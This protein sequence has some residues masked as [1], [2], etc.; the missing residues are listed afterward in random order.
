MQS[1]ALEILVGFFVCLG[2]AAVFLLTF[3][4]ASLNTVG[5]GNSYQVTADFDSIGSLAPGASVK[6]AGVKIGRVKSIG[7]DSKSFQAVV[8]LEIDGSQSNIPVDSTAKIL[9]AGL[10]GEQ[11]VG[12]EPGGDDQSLKNGSQIKFTQ[13]ALV[14]ENLIGQ[15]LT[16]F[17]QK[18]NN[19]GNQQNQNQNAA[20]A[21]AP[22][23]K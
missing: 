23:S 15:F 2:V 19:Q 9:T 22:K 5:G 10:L 17:A 16:S 1:R 20:P 14:L 6:L 13:S 18:D 11:Y 7:I 8:T 21:P 4:V 3:R 12:I